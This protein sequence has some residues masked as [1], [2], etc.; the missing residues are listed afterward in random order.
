MELMADLSCSTDG[1][2][3]NEEEIRAQ[4]EHYTCCTRKAQWLDV[5]S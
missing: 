2:L 5:V 3:P 4:V 1:N